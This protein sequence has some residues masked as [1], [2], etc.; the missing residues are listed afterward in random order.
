VFFFKLDPSHWQWLRLRLEYF[1]NWNSKQLY[2]TK[3]WLAIFCRKCVS[4]Y[5]NPV[6]ND[7]QYHTPYGTANALPGPD[8]AP[9]SWADFWGTSDE[10]PQF[11]NGIHIL[12]LVTYLLAQNT[13][14]LCCFF[15][16][17]FCYDSS[18]TAWPY[19]IWRCLDATIRLY[20][21]PWLY[22]HPHR[23]LLEKFIPRCMFLH[24]LGLQAFAQSM[25]CHISL[26]VHC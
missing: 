3:N 16:C 5:K 18:L 11:P 25:I 14:N 21:N 17:V 8:S 1:W 9:T 12:P 19:Q 6:D 20:C 24:H 22:L 4:N 13:S 10:S 15:L 2:T 26:F 7:E 23:I